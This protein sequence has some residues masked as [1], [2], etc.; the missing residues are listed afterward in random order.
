[1]KLSDLKKIDSNFVNIPDNKGKTP[2]LHAAEKENEALFEKFLELGAKTD[3]RGPNG[4][5]LLHYAAKK[6]NLTILAKALELLKNIE[7]EDENGSTPLIYAATAANAEAVK[8]L[9]ENG[10]NVNHVDKFG[11][12]ALMAVSSIDNIEML[13]VILSAGAKT[14]KN[15]AS[16]TNPLE[17]AMWADLEVNFDI[18]LAA[19]AK[20]ADN[21][22]SFIDNISWFHDNDRK[23]AW[24]KKLLANGFDVNTIDRFGRTLLMLAAEQDRPDLLKILLDSGADKSLK[25]E[26]LDYTA[27]NFAKDKKHA[28]C[29][30]LLE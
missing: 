15:S 27:L 21:A 19:G 7:I 9:L 4:Q 24:L 22:S 16:W 3:A 18:L 28:A 13:K 23:V 25:Y 2:L 30:K 20:V 29:I 1:M 5:T 14:E 17:R 8:F 10:A 11:A 6:P 12:C 26:P